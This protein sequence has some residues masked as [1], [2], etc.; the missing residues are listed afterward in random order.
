MRPMI[1]AAGLFALATVLL[2]AL[3]ARAE[4]GAIAY[5]GKT[6]RSGW[7]V[8]EPSAPRAAEKAIS[9]CGGSD[10]KV[11]VKIGPRMCGAL[12]RIEG[13]KHVGA[14]ERP[15]RDAARLAALNDCKKPNL[16]ECVVKFNECNR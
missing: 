1:A 6:G 4:Y 13:Q 7:A 5:D 2:A 15:D 10:C 8:H 11:V 14:A 9:E 16:G 3:P 12:A